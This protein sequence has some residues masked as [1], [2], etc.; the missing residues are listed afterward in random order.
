VVVLVTLHVLS[1]A[2]LARDIFERTGPLIS[3]SLAIDH[4]F[5]G[6]ATIYRIRRVIPNTPMVRVTYIVGL[7][8]RLVD[9]SPLTA[10]KVERRMSQ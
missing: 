10:W 9:I 2:A 6:T 1:A 5:E 7:S 8:E 3:P 4:F